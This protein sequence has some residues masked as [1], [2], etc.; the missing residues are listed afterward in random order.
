MSTNLSS[1]PSPALS[2]SS[3]DW[4]SPSHPFYHIAPIIR[5]SS[6]V[7]LFSLLC[8]FC[9]HVQELPAGQSLSLLEQLSH[10]IQ[11]IFLEKLPS[12]GIV[13]LAE[14]QQRSKKRRHSER[15][16]GRVPSSE[17]NPSHFVAAL[18]RGVD[19][20]SLV[21]LNTP[22]SLWTSE[23]M[24]RERATLAF[25]AVQRDVCVPLMNAARDTVS[26]V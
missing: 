19:L 24:Y 10:S 17:V 18:S 23:G 13:G 3:E 11:S 22:V 20:L 8:R 16:T 7:S 12:L 21:L 2:K 14:K 26:S 15:K 9:R 1:S 4:Y 6:C 5:H 25:L